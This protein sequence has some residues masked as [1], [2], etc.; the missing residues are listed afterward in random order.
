MNMMHHIRRRAWALAG[1][2]LLV[3][4]LAAQTTPVPPHRTKPLA[5]STPQQ[6][7]TQQGWIH[8]D[9]QVGTDLQLEQDRLQRM[10]AIDDEFRER[11]RALGTTPWSNAGYNDL[12]RQREQMI[13]R[14]LTPTQYDRWMVHSDCS[15]PPR[16]SPAPLCHLRPDSLLTC[17]RRS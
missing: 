5:P 16:H 1:T 17:A 11:Y 14:G 9:E 10:R 12:T 7:S 3:L 8:F 4:G 2:F 13:Q 15:I 6:N